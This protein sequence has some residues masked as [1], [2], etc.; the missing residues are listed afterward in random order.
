M[1]LNEIRVDD[2]DGVAAR[3]IRSSYFSSS[4][5]LDLVCGSGASLILGDGTARLTLASNDTATFAG[6]VV[7][8]DN[9]KLHGGRVHPRSV[10]STSNTNGFLIATDVASNNYAMI[11]GEIDLIQF[12]SSTKQRIEFS[13]TLNNNGTVFN[14]KGTADIDITIKL[15]VYNS[16]WYVHVPQPSTYTTCTAYISKANATF[17]NMEKKSWQ[18]LKEN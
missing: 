14:K 13:A 2:N 11:Q 9:Q 6:D 12:N 17:G 3:K 15:F 8:G 7:I 18:H 5:N 4:Q 10:Y 16:K 1:S